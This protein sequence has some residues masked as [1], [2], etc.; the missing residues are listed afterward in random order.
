MSKFSFFN[1]KKIFIS[2]PIIL[3]S[4]IPFFLITG[5]FLPDLIV[6]LCAVI[7]L[8]NSIK[9]SLFSYYKSFYFLFFILFYCILLLSSLNSDFTFLSLK[10]SLPYLRFGIFT[11]STWYLLDQDR[12]LVNKIFNVTFFSFLL[13][14]I[15]GFFQFFFG[16][17]L[18]GWKMIDTPRL[19]SFFGKE[20]ILG[21]FLA[22]LMPLLFSCFILL[23]GNL[24]KRT[25]YLFYF[26]FI[27]TEI[28]IF[29]SGERTSFFL[30]N[31][32]I[33]F[34]IILSKKFGKIRFYCWLISLTLILTISLF[35]KNSFTRIFT[36]TAE[37]IGFKSEEKYIFSKQHEG[38]Y[39]SAYKMFLKNKI[40]GVGPKLFREKCHLE[41]YKAQYSCSTHP[42]NTY[43]Q[44]LAETGVLGF[45][46]IFFLFINLLFFSLK[47]FY[48]KFFLKKYLFTDY[49]LS[50][51][52]SLLITLWPF[53]PS[54]N[55][56]NNWLNV[57]YYLPLGFLIWSFK[58]KNI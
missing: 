23:Y 17:N 54:G 22:R 58:K 52:S 18:L 48:Y 41:E 50:L 5:P 12:S 4:L 32:S 30:L 24:K 21:S 8:I 16:F 38:H 15:D 35:N 14:I 34:I 57:V 42:H 55:F 19:S 46:F 51:F 45:L 31:L 10:S 53:V 37:Q 33:F 3:T 25:E 49:S 29:L 44:L 40:L 2:I 27:L 43:I 56:F 9:N 1:E 6:S 36:L 28:L 26:V 13:L 11:L 20:W 47:Q 39:I 7:F